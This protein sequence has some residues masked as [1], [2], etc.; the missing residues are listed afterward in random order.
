MKKFPDNNLMNLKK[1]KKIYQHIVMLK[2]I[3][4]KGY[5]Q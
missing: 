3:F 4:K 1:I 5:F 2:N